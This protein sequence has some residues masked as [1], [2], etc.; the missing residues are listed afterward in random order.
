M[1][2]FGL[3]T[4][5]PLNSCTLLCRVHKR[6]E[7]HVNLTE[8]LGNTDGLLCERDGGAFSEAYR[9]RPRASVCIPRRRS[10]AHLIRQLMYRKALGSCRYGSPLQSV[11]GGGGR[12]H[13]R[14]KTSQTP[15]PPLSRGRKVLIC[16]I[17]TGKEQPARGHRGYPAGISQKRK[18]ATTMSNRHP[19]A[20]V[21]ERTEAR[22]NARLTFLPRG[23]IKNSPAASF[24]PWQ[25]RPCTQMFLN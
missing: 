19:V 11:R 18:K 7:I 12:L 2:Q 23:I 15:G 16:D 25:R 3:Q 21:S 6:S 24:P 22:F 10:V 20:A 8:P 4:F 17:G 1:M 14:L 9:L 5:F 13:L